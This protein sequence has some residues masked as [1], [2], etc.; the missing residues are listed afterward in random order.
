MVAGDIIPGLGPLA[1]I[2]AAAMLPSTPDVDKV[3]FPYGRPD[4]GVPQMANPLFYAKQA[5]PSWLRKAITAGD[6][7][8][9]E[10][11]RAY[12]N[13]VKEIQRA[14]FMTQTYDCLL[15]TSPS[16]RDGLLSRMPSSA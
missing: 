5:I 9:V 6:S 7:M 4:E 14:M 1:Q 15:Y 10:F 3:F 2:P 13:Q 12:A 8:D 11:Q 16:P